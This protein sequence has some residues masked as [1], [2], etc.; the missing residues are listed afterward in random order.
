MKNN[1]TIRSMTKED[2]DGVLEVEHESFSVPWSRQ[3]FLDEAENSHTV[4][5]VCCD[6]KKITAYGGMWHVLNEGQITNI[7]VKPE[8]RR[9]GIASALLEHLKKS[10]KELGITLM[11]LEV[12][13]GNQA[14]IGLYKKQGFETVGRRRRYYTNPTEDAILMNLEL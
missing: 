1:Y 6:G 8:Y 4:Y 10:A 2:I 14:A 11:E 7:A 12:R 13:E 3:L 5:F 9:F